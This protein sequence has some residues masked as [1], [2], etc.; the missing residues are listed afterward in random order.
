MEV[1]YGE[2]EEDTRVDGE[3]EEG[4]VKGE[5]EEALGVRRDATGYP[6][7]RR[8]RGLDST[9]NAHLRE[10]WKRNVS[11]SLASALYAS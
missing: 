3:G 5:A 6:Y 9:R 10:R 1:L 11:T 8:P 7:D 4:A 2:E